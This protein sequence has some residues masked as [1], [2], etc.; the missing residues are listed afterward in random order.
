MSDAIDGGRRN[1]VVNEFVTLRSFENPKDWR[2]VSP[3]PMHENQKFYARKINLAM[4]LV[5]V[6]G[7]DILE[8]G[9]LQIAKSIHK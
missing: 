1:Y 9:I 4:W 2:I 6:D 8:L 7:L 3:F 5:D